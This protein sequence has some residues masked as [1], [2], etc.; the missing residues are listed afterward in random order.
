MAIQLQKEQ[1]FSDRASLVV[2]RTIAILWIL[3]GFLGAC[4]LL[5]IPLFNWSAA[6]MSGGRDTVFSA[7]FAGL[8]I[9]AGVSLWL[10]LGWGAVIWFAVALFYSFAVLVFA[11]GW[12]S[13]LSAI[14][15][16]IL[17]LIHS[18]YRIT[19]RKDAFIE[20]LKRS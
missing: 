6:T 15:V 8:D 19:L 16:I 3:K 12:H 1:S 14:I 9:V 5:G 18:G 4:D 13:V 7:L 2:Y 17:L 11:P 10:S 20:K